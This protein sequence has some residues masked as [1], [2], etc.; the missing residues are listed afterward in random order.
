MA[1]KDIPGSVVFPLAN[2]SIVFVGTFIG[3]IF[4]KDRPDNRQ[5]IGLALASIS[6]FLLVI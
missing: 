1:L 4:W 6:I 5:W 3:V 2:L